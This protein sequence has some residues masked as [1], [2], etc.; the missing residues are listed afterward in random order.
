MSKFYLTT[1]IYYVN[2]TP[3]IGHTC[4]TLAADILARY[5]KQL[6]NGVFFLTGTDEH[7]AKVAEAAKK[8]GKEPQAFTDEVSQRFIKD[9]KLL[10]IDY[11]YFIRT[12]DP[13][14]MKLA[15]TFIQKMYAKGDIYKDKYQ[16][17][18]CVGCEK[19]I[20]E[21]E[22]VDGKC[23]L[24]DREPEKQSE[25]NYFFKLKDYVLKPG[26]VKELIEKDRFKVS[27][28]NKK[29]EI[30]NKIESGVEDLSISRA[31]VP[32][33]VPIPWDSKQTIYVWYEALLNYWTA[34]QIVG[35][36][37]W[38]AD[39]H[40][41]GKEIAWFHCVIWP[42]MLLSVGEK[43]PKQIFVHDFYNLRGTKM[44][45]SLG[46]V[47][48]PKV[49]VGKFGVDGA[50]FVLASFFPHSSDTALS[51]ELMVDKYNA[52]LA[53]GLG[54][55]VARLGKLCEKN[56]IKL[57]LPKPT[58][59][60]TTN[61]NSKYLE[62]YELAKALEE[63]WKELVEKLLSINQ[64]LKPFMLQTA[65]IIESVFTAST[66]RPPTPLFPRV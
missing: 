43:L 54:N 34:P 59:T 39:L 33:G 14:H 19:F 28:D 45:K 15:Q 25:E 49:L 13:K 18:Y 60:P 52:D 51:W 35:K 6:G 41:I 65:E 61:S 30:L 42:A 58:P 16:G 20:T 23:P 66:I 53:N 32:W 40:L 5:H 2:D 22:L 48:T 44:S 21:K 36:D 8:A 56:E 1:P 29:K 12:T 55:L 27:P 9:W 62:K 17:L 47:I 38:P 24:H 63:I 11:D 37:L 3:H 4:T 46:N 64:S 7:G 50:R 31:N 57:K 26:G 10:N